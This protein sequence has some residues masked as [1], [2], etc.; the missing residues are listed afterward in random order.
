MALILAQ[1]IDARAG[2]RVSSVM[3]RATGIV[4]GVGF[5]AVARLANWTMGVMF[6]GGVCSVCPSGISPL[7]RT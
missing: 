7:D 1:C 3:V 6:D 2:S 4:V 5:G